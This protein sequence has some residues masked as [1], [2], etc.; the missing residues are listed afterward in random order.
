MDVLAALPKAAGAG[1]RPR[2]APRPTAPAED[3]LEEFAEALRALE[4]A[5]TA[6]WTALPA[7]R[8]AEFGPVAAVAAQ[9]VIF[10]TF[11]GV[12]EDFVG[13]ADLLEPGFGIRLLADV[14]ME[15]ARQPAVGLLDFFRRSLGRDTQHFVVVDE[16]HA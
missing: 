11:V 15:L 5:G 3:R 9:L 10:G 4:I 16:L 2:A 8:R 12:F 6:G 1:T 7:R 13:L 14:R